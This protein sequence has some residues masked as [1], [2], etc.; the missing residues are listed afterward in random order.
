MS[1]V[2]KLLS[3]YQ[4]CREDGVD[5]R[6]SLEL[7][8]GVET[9]SFTNV[10]L[11]SSGGQPPFQGPR[12]KRKRSRKNRKRL[13][14]SDSSVDAL[15]AQN[16]YVDV[17]SVQKKAASVPHISAVSSVDAS[18]VQEPDVAV[19]SFKEESAADAV[20]VVHTEDERESESESNITESMYEPHI[21]TTPGGTVLSVLKPVPYLCQYE[22]YVEPE[23]NQPCQVYGLCK[24]QNCYSCKFY[25]KINPLPKLKFCSTTHCRFTH[26]HPLNQRCR[27]KTSGIS[28][29]PLFHYNI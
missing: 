9:F 15:H 24:K 20:H 17:P 8:N 13:N 19:S 1:V 26:W 11:P 3:I 16:N 23:P 28:N 6:L 29:T 12:K 27:K 5:V 25:D 18:Y 14:L 21:V 10:L 22:H 2:H 4:Q 7:K